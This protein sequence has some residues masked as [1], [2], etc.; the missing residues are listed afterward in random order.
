MFPFS[1]S[2]LSFLGI[3]ASLVQPPL[4]D[5]GDSAHH[6]ELPGTEHWSELCDFEIRTRSASVMWGDFAQSTEWYGEGEVFLPGIL[7]KRGIVLK[8]D[9]A[10]A[11]FGEA[12]TWETSR[13]LR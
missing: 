4:P 3:D 12:I 1:S 10:D 8:L 6:H 2:I 13:N 7:G 5:A 9:D 11:L